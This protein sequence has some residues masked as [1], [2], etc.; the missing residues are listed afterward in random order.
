MLDTAIGGNAARFAAAVNKRA[1]D[2]AKHREWLNKNREVFPDDI[3]RIYR[4]VLRQAFKDIAAYFTMV[5]RRETG[6]RRLGETYETLK[7]T[8]NAKRAITWAVK[9]DQDFHESCLL[10]AEKPEEVRFRMMRYI[11]RRAPDSARELI[12]KLTQGTGAGGGLGKG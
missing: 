12:F 1:L 4:A 11:S 9:A 2:D 8:L 7:I 3:V 5:R 10:A 6:K